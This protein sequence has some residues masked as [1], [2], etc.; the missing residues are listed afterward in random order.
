MQ[1]LLV[2][3]CMDCAAIISEGVVSA[4]IISEAVHG[5]CSYYQLLGHVYSLGNHHNKEK[6][7]AV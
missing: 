5:Q 2:T 4:A 3:L 1:I 6:F 7:M